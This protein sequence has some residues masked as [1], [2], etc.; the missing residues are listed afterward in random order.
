MPKLDRENSKVFFI[1]YRLAEM[2]AYN[3]TIRVSTTDLAKDIGLSQQSTSRILMKMERMGLIERTSTR[4]G[5]FIKISRGGEDL[6][7]KVHLGLTAIFEGKPRSIIVEGRVFSGLGEGAYYVSRE[8][9]RRQFIE[10][11]GFDPY[12]G[13]LNL[14][15][16][17]EQNARLRMDLDAYP[18]IEI[19]GFRN[20]D[21]TY[22]PVK[23]FHAIINDREK[24]AV[25]FALRSHYGK[26]VIEIIAPKYLRGQL[27]LKDGDKVKVEIFL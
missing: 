15:I 5:S 22:G 21:R 7:R 12:P 2:G 8:P 18:G 9:Y 11:L 26:D 3:R 1:L 25:V 4:E 6:L 20:R 24:G 14:K 23:C 10:K 17:S 16:T 13:T 27:G 19:Q